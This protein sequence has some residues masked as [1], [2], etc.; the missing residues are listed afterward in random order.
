MTPNSVS[1]EPAAGQAA[2]YT[3]YADDITLSSNKV[4][5][6]LEIEREIR[7]IVGRTKRPTLRF[8]ESKRGIY[9]SAGRRII[10]GLVIT[11]AKKVSLGRMRKRAISA[12]IHHIETERNLSPRHLANTKGWLAFALSVEPS[13]VGSMRSKYGAIV[14]RIM[15][16]ET[17]RRVSLATP[18]T[19][20]EQ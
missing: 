1:A 5:I 14:D 13:F 11:P 2:V 7:R 10:T 8:N 15:R 20:R 6:L 19:S 9:T 18:E 4:E 17:P 3:R 12:A 16:T